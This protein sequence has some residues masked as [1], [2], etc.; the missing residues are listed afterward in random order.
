MRRSRCPVREKRRKRKKDGS[1]IVPADAGLVWPRAH[2][3]RWPKPPSPP[4]RFRSLWGRRLRRGEEEEGEDEEE[5]EEEEE[6]G[7]WVRRRRLALWACWG[8]LQEEEERGRW[9]RRR[10]GG[11]EGRRAWGGGD[12]AGEEEEEERRPRLW[13][14]GRGGAGGGR[15]FS[16]SSFFLVEVVGGCPRCQSRSACVFERVGGGRRRVC[17]RGLDLLPT[18]GGW[19]GGCELLGSPVHSALSRLYGEDRL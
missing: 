19:V 4:A 11:G 18:V 3:T 7:W 5:E 9:W 12:L 6:G 14:R 8:L 16:S 13:G 2:S 1:R 17:H 10:R 15:F